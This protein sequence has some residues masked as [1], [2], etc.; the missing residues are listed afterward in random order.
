MNGIV[1]TEVPEK[2]ADQPAGRTLLET[3]GKNERMRHVPSIEWIEWKVDSDL[4]RRIGL[5][6]TIFA[7]MPSDDARWTALDGQFRALCRG[8]ERL[9]DIARHSRPTTQAPAELGARIDWALNSATAALRSID[10][11][12]FGRRYPFQTFE[13]SKAEPLYG[14][15]LLLLDS[16]CRLALAIRAVDPSIDEQLLLGMVQLERPLP[17]RPMA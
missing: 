4:R 5:L 15:L 7:A 12:L 3:W 2:V 14:A 11:T 9:C 8:I 13:R 1:A 16:V 17:E 10:P 6:W